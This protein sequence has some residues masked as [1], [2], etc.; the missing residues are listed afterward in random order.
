M[1]IQYIKQ[2]CLQYAEGTRHI[3]EEK[4][5]EKTREKNKNRNRSQI[6][7]QAEI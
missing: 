2:K 1:H 4:G 7:P 3:N 5:K 6:S